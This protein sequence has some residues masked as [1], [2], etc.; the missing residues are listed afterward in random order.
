[1]IIHQLFGVCKSHKYFRNLYFF[2]FWVV[3]FFLEHIS[4]NKISRRNLAEN[5]LNSFR[6]GSRSG[7]F[8]KSDP[9]P[10][11]NRPDPQHWFLHLES[12]TCAKPLLPAE[13]EL[14]FIFTKFG[15]VV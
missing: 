13:P 14:K 7:R 3:V 5:S 12:F 11:K 8:Q 10:V 2:P 6:S 15:P 9:D 4:A 1:M